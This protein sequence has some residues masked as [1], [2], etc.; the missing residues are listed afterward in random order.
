MNDRQKPNPGVSREA[1]ISDDG[2]KRLERQLAVGS[3]LTDVV[4]QQW[5][6]R[7]GKGAEELIEKFTDQDG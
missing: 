6:K 5:I 2:L 4:L 1:R 3:K 7:Y